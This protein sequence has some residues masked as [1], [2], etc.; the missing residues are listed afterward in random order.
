MDECAPSPRRTT[1]PSRSQSASGVFLVLRVLRPSSALAAGTMRT[2]SVAQGT[3]A[4][5]M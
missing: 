2:S 5:R 3:D 4:R 1:T